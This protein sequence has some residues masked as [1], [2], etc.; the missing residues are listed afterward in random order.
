MD[1]PWTILNLS[2]E[3][4]P[5]GPLSPKRILVPSSQL[6]TPISP[7]RYVPS[8]CERFQS[9]TT[10]PISGSQKLQLIS[11]LRLAWPVF[12]QRLY[13]PLGEAFYP[14]SASFSFRPKNLKY[15]TKRD[16]RHETRT[17]S[18]SAFP[19]PSPTPAPLAMKISVLAPDHD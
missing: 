16:T 12:F 5:N 17:Q 10:A 7:A 14:S 9:L 13:L 3:F 1:H 18:A 19:E 6:C 11:L 15:K 4:A 2:L 8:A